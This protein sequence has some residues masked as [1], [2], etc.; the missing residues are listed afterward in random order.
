MS[1]R[2]GSMAVGM[3]FQSRH[4]KETP[5]YPRSWLA[6]WGLFLGIAGFF[7]GTLL[8]W[9]C[10]AGSAFTF[11]QGPVLTLIE[12]NDAIADTD[13]H[14][15]QGIKL[16]YLQADNHAPHWA[17]RLSDHLP[18]WGFEN[19]ADKFGYEIGQ[20]F[21]TPADLKASQLL[22]DDRPYAGWLYTGLILQRRGLDAH[23]H[24]VLEHFELQLGII[25]PESF[26]EQTQ[27][28][29]HQENGRGW[30]HQLKTEPGLALRYQRSWLITPAGK[31]ARHVDFIPY[32]GFSLGNVETSAR[33][34]ALLR[35]GWNL[36]DDFGI[37][38][39]DSLAVTSGG[40]SRSR[41][42][43]PWGFYVFTGV[44]ARAVLHNAF[45]DGNLYRASHSV[46]K[47]PIVRDW[48]SGIVFV[49]KR[50]DVGLAYVL[51]SP[52]FT[53]QTEDDRYG[54][55]FINVKF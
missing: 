42:A 27:N 51:R 18:E 21:Y 53:S 8:A 20:N 31:E 50:V 40:W 11:D 3:R 37:P 24:P 41:A 33:F 52:E 34:G 5:F 39:I 48:K 43:S 49:L 30:D 22:S 1:N 47:E 46:G 28:W 10:Q 36:P 32:G 16:A 13:R 29:A 7:E 19:K 45:L 12:E 4:W 54:S 9:N 15:T 6:T 23:D 2:S 17:V 44:D 35:I 38:I 55:L 25:G 14:Y 26:A